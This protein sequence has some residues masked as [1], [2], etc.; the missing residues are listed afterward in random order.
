MK[1]L[2]LVEI[3]KISGAG[4]LADVAAN[5]G[6]GF[7]CITYVPPDQMPVPVLGDQRLGI[8]IGEII[9]SVLGKL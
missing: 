2:N 4:Q 6:D 7:G 9:Q 8:N 5:L 3:E 1:E